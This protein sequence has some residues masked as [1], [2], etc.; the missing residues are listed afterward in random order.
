MCAA[1]LS[2]RPSRPCL[3]LGLPVAALVLALFAG[4]S[5]TPRSG[6][7]DQGDGPGQRPAAELDRIPDATPR[8]EPLASGPNRPYV[9]FG[10]HYVPQTADLPY[11]QRGL[12]SWYGR[13]FHGRPTSS[14]ERYDMYAM[15]AAHPTLPI[16]SYARVRHLGNGREVIVRINDRGPFKSERIIDLSYAAA[17]RLGFVQQGQAEVEVERIT[18]AEIRAGR[19]PRG[20][21][22][23]PEPAPPTRPAPVADEPLHWVQLGAFRQR[24]GAEHFLSQVSAQV[25]WLAPRLT[26]VTE[27]SLHRLQAGPYASR[28][29]ALAAAE[30]IREALQLVPVIVQR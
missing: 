21:V 18:H 2:V 22:E 8:I 23:A 10:R 5:S 4:C 1:H 12:A 19:W 11:R 6:G 28:D 20:P 24:D 25:A 3:R 26:I 15:T 7:Y 27:A 13:Q 17:H 16:P 9:M 29:E 14:G 30:R